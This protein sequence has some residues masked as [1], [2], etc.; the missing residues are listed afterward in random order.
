M[1]KFD[2]PAVPTHKPVSHR[3]L[4][5]A[6]HLQYI[7]EVELARHLQAQK[8]FTAYGI[9]LALQHN[10]PTLEIVHTEV[11][12]IVHARMAQSCI[13]FQR[14]MRVHGGEWALTYIPISI[15]VTTPP[16]FEL[17]AH[18][19]WEDEKRAAT[20]SEKLAPFILDAESAPL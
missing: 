14:Q 1:C 7:V 17:P 15:T 10:F 8:T 3:Q 16:V 13:P 12:Q 4:V 20:D 11:R 6:S 9:T 19:A 5:S 2:L 18:I